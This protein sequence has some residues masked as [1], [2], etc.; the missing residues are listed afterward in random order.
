MGDNVVHLFKSRE[1][2]AW[3]IRFDKNP[4]EG[5]AKDDPHPVLAY[6]KKEAGYR[7]GFSDADGKGGWGKPWADG[8][9]NYTEH[10]GARAV[11]RKCADM[12]GPVKEVERDPF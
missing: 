4:N 10:M 8:Q 3:L 9:F 6:L 5:R 11:L 7:W 2:R 12:L 1:D